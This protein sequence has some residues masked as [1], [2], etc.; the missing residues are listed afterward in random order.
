MLLLNFQEQSTRMVHEAQMTN[1]Q[2]GG[3]SG[4]ASSCEFAS[5]TQRLAGQSWY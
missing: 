2:R 4:Y 1:T 5:V 3:R